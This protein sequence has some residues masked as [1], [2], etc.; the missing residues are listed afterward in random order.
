MLRSSSNKFNINICSL[1]GKS[2]ALSL[3]AEYCSNDQLIMCRNRLCNSMCESES[4]QIGNYAKEHRILTWLRSRLHA[5][6]YDVVFSLLSFV[7]G[8]RNMTH[9]LSSAY[10]EMILSYHLL[11]QQF[12]FT[13]NWN[14][15][16][17]CCVVVCFLFVFCVVCFC[18]CLFFV[19]FLLLVLCVSVLV[20]W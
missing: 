18:F 19:L 16:R 6:T 14:L 15:S 17:H 3:P 11:P 4:S 13:H 2:I 1:S 20:L 8:L 7:M 10:A 5:T 9:K 12:F